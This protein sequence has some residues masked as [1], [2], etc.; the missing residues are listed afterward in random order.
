MSVL[1]YWIPVEVGAGNV[2]RENLVVSVRADFPR[3]L[4]QFTDK[5]FNPDSVTV[6]D[7]NQQEIPSQYDSLD[8]TVSWRE[9]RNGRTG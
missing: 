1:R 7:E 6:Y 8:E 5:W 4:N 9:G 3:L 2:K